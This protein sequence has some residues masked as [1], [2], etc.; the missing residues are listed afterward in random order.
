MMPEGQG[1]GNRQKL[2]QETEAQR[3]AFEGLLFRWVSLLR[4]LA[5]LL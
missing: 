4:G 3:Q 5:N 1:P 2:M